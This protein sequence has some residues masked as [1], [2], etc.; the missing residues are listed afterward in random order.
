MNI[1]SKRFVFVLVCLAGVAVSSSV[2]ASCPKDESQIQSLIAGFARSLHVTDPARADQ[3]IALVKSVATGQKTSVSEALS[4]GVSPNTTFQWPGGPVSSLLSIAAAT[5]QDDIARTLVAAGADP[6]GSGSSV[7]PLSI[8]AGNGDTDLVSFLL[9]RGAQIDKV[10]A[11]GQ[12]PL[13][14]AVRQHQL[15]TVK[16][17]LQHDPNPARSI[18]RGAN[19]LDLVANSP[20]STD[21]AIAQVL[22]SYGLKNQ[23][24]AQ[25]H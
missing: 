20:D 19:V 16:V 3:D 18:G 5:C 13:E 11:M 4:S 6:D 15:E 10:D 12:Y 8:A 17:I 14:A 1:Y 9:E 23:L 24:R 2:F 25:D 22:R 7:P 21:Q